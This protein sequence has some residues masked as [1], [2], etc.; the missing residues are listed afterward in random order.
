MIHGDFSFPKQNGFLFTL[1]FMKHFSFFYFFIDNY[2]L[3]AV[4]STA[5]LT[6]VISDHAQLLLDLL[7]TLL[8]KTYPPGD[9]IAH[10]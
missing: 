4:N 2:F 3:S 8:Q 6:I 10:C 5:Y 7:S 1:R 9:W